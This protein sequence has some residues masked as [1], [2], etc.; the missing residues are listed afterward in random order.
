MSTY[1]SFFPILARCLGKAD[2]D[3]VPHE[4]C[5]KYFECQN[6]RATEKSCPNYFNFVKDP[7]GKFFHPYYKTCV[8]TTTNSCPTFSKST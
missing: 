4:D 1:L 2:Y 5:T 3:R 8:N 6:Q 7:N